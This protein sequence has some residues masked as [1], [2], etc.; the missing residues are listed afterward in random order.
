MS[1]ILI[2][3]VD[4]NAARVFL[5]ANSF[6]NSKKSSLY[7]IENHYYLLIDCTNNKVLPDYIRNGNY[8]ELII[9]SEIEI[10]DNFS[11]S[12]D[13]VYSWAKSELEQSI[14]FIEFE[15]ISTPKQNLRN[16][17]YF[18]GRMVTYN[19]IEIIRTFEPLFEIMAI[20]NYTADSFSDGGNYNNIA[21]MTQQ[22]I[23]QVNAGATIIDLGVESTRPNAMTLTATQEIEMLQE[24]LPKVLELKQQYKFSLSIDTYHNETVLWLLAMDMNFDIINDVSGNINLELVDKIIG[25]D[26]KYIAMHSLSI[27]A[28]PQ[29]LILDDPVKAL[30]G[31]FAQKI[32]QFLAY[33]ILF[34][35]IITNVI[36]DPGLGFGKNSVQ[37]WYILN[38]ISKIN[39]LGPQLLLGHSRKSF[40]NHVINKEFSRRD[41]DTAFIAVQLANFFGIIRIHDTITTLDLYALNAQFNK[42]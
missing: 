13:L 24:I 39:T 38:N 31:F 19:D 17:D 11:A 37:S 9:I 2:K 33:G 8:K 20:I 15:T 5:L 40:L 26:K 18:I 16:A 25:K 27:P 36:F 41:L 4:K 1:L 3:F 28:N 22:I 6:Q 42:F 23:E 10:V 7:K 14:Q 34:D 30:N 35:K 29:N 21:S 32:K 12:E